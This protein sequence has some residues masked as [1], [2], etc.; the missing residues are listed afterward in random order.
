MRSS[1]NELEGKRRVRVA[2]A[3]EDV[4]I[5]IPDEFIQQLGLK[6]GDNVNASVVDGVLMVKPAKKL[7]GEGYIEE[8]YGKPA[9]DINSIETEVVDWGKPRGDEEW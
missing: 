9:G 3:G 5:P 7:K 1:N 4:F 8:Y 6:E 2:Q